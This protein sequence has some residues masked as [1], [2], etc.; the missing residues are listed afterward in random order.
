MI[1][2]KKKANRF[3]FEYAQLKLKKSILSVDKLQKSNKK[4]TDVES[5]ISINSS[6][7]LNKKTN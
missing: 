6:L 1:R 4:P 5:K 2:K 7:K 3:M